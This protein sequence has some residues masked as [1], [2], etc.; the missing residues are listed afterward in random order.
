MAAD[1]D[2]GRSMDDYC[3]DE[4]DKYDLTIRMSV[5][6]GIYEDGRQAYAD[7]AAVTNPELARSYE[8]A[9]GS[10]EALVQAANDLVSKKQDAAGKSVQAD[11]EEDMQKVDERNRKAL[12]GHVREMMAK[13]KAAGAEPDVLRVMRK[14]LNSPV[15][16]CAL[17]SGSLTKLVWERL[18]INIAHDMIGEL[19]ERVRRHLDLW[20]ILIEADPS[21]TTLAYLRLLSRCYVRGLDTECVILCRSVLDVVFHDHLPKA[22][23]DSLRRLNSRGDPPLSQRINAAERNKL[24]SKQTHRKAKAVNLRGNKAVHGDPSATEDIRGTI[25]DTLTVV[26]ELTDNS[27]EN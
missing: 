23:E 18:S 20:G 3:A 19:D 10:A 24:I 22:L 4:Y 25:R 26:G 15:R 21:E 13:L 17:E 7:R 2:S 11:V 27:P 6:I 5:A 14:Y 12:A 16:E 8:M 1:E 9:D